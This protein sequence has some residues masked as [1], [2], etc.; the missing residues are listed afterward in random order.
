[1]RDQQAAIRIQLDLL[2]GNDNCPVRF[3]RGASRQ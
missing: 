1:M 2:R 3:R